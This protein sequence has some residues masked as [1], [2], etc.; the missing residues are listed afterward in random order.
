MVLNSTLIGRVAVVSADLCQYVACNPERLSP[1]HVLHLL[2]CFPF[3]QLRR[4]A[5]C[6][7]AFFCSPSHPD[8][9]DSHSD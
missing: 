8:D 3:Q 6:I 2:F 4:L 9:S 5:L 7:S 1:E